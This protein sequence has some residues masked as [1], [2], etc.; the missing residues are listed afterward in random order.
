MPHLGVQHEVPSH[1]GEQLRTLEFEQEV[2]IQQMILD[3]ELHPK[4]LLDMWFISLMG[5]WK[6]V[7]SKVEAPESA[8][9]EAEKMSRRVV[10]R[11][12]KIHNLPVS[13]IHANHND[14][15]LGLPDVHEFMRLAA[16]HVVCSLAFSTDPLICE[17]FGTYLQMTK[18]INNIASLADPSNFTFFDCNT[19]SS[20]TSC[21]SSLFPC[22]WCVDGE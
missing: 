20:C 8:G 12:L 17:F 22:D 7:S 5:K 2:K 19:Y 3:P 21:V 9:E 10:R 1:S 4:M 13:C 6:Y 16:L 18:R 15:G 14:F 11:I